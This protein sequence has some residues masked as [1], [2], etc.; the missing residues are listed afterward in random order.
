MIHSAFQTAGRV[1][2]L[3]AILYVDD[4]DPVLSKYGLGVS[5]TMTT[6]P[7]RVLADTYNRLATMTDAPILFSGA[8]DLIFRT[9]YWD[10]QVRAR[11]AA[12]P[13]CLVYGDDLFQGAQL[14]THPFISHAAVDALGYFYPATGDVSLTDVWLMLMYRA[15]GRLR[16]VPDV[17]IEH[18]HFLNGKAEYDETYAGQ[19][20]GNFPRVKEA[21]TLRL[22]QLEADTRRLH[23]AIVARQGDTVGPSSDN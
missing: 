5:C 19:Y 3:E 7:R 6:G 15:L 2:A 9:P 14:C 16:Y 10:E 4:D 12:D 18:M 20:E 11:F 1:D 17:V 13:F 21:L 22:P 8:D 23:A